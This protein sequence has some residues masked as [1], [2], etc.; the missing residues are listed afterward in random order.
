MLAWTGCWTNSWVFGY[1]GS[2]DAHV[3]DNFSNTSM[4]KYSVNIKP[5]THWRYHGAV[6]SHRYV[7]YVVICSHKIKS[8]HVSKRDIISHI[9]WVRNRQPLISHSFRR[10]TFTCFHKC[11]CQPKSYKRTPYDLPIDPWH[12][13]V[14]YPSYHDPALQWMPMRTLAP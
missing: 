11:S 14:T 8:C 12:A 5:S 1:L 6:L 13:Y 4:V 9:F 10:N 3:M 7:L 2:Y